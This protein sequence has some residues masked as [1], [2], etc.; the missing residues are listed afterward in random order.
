MNRK[1]SAALVGTAALVALTG[2]SSSNQDSSQPPAASPSQSASAPAS[3]SAGS[4]SPAPAKSEAAQPAVITIKDFAYSGPSSVAPGSTI[5]VMNEDDVAHTVTA[6]EGSAFDV[7]VPPGES[8]MLT[9]PG[10]AGSYAFHCTY[11]SNMHGTLA[12]K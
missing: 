7:N 1:F 3:S 6:D 8:A 2:C 11:H 9:A 12:V 5:T 4:P 10:K